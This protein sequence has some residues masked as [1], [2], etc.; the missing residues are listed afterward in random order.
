M[1]HCGPELEFLLNFREGLPT[2]MLYAKY[3]SSFSSLSINISHNTVQTLQ[4][5]KIPELLGVFQEYS[6]LTCPISFAE[7][8]KIV[9]VCFFISQSILSSAFYM[10]AS[11]EDSKFPASFN[12]SGMLCAY[13]EIYSLLSAD[14]FRE[15]KDNMWNDADTV[16]KAWE[17]NCTSLTQSLVVPVVPPASFYI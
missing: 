5:L 14:K 4:E 1:C 3:F 16:L 7:F 15:Y 2:P 10:S 12:E 8:L 9:T 13:K 17:V 11:L 6:G